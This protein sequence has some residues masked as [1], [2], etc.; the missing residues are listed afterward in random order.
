MLDPNEYHAVTLAFTRFFT[1]IAM[2]CIVTNMVV[3]RGLVTSLHA[4]SAVILLHLC[5]LVGDAY[6][7]HLYAAFPRRET[8]DALLAMNQ[9]HYI[10]VFGIFA[11]WVLGMFALIH[12]LRTARDGSDI[13]LTIMRPFIIFLTKI[14]L[15]SLAH[16]STLMALW[17]TFFKHVVA[18]CMPSTA[19]KRKVKLTTITNGYWTTDV[20]IMFHLGDAVIF[21]IFV[22]Y[23]DQLYMSISAV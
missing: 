10:L 16:V 6:Y 2:A 13:P 22:I 7:V 14:S 20:T 8:G 23:M 21:W 19:I 17:G 5:Y 15:D 18:L 4:V 11:G 1:D 3:D 12:P 9:A